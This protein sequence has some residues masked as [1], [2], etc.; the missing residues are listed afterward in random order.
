MI[1]PGDTVPL[2]MQVDDGSDFFAVQLKHFEKDAVDL[3]GSVAPMVQD[4][5]M[6]EAANPAWFLQ[7]LIWNGFSPTPTADPWDTPYFTSTEFDAEVWADVTPQPNP[8]TFNL[9]I[10]PGTGPGWYDLEFAVA[11]EFNPLSYDDQHFYVKVIPEPST[12]V[13]LGLGLSGLGLVGWRRRRRR[14]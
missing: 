4:F 6:W 5:A 13:L 7:D 3:G 12:F 10:P 1:T 8:R 14:T 9:F 2:D 11:V